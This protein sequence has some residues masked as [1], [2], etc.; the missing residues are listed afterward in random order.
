MAW[1][2]NPESCIA[3]I[4]LPVLEIVLGIDNVIFI[5][6]LAGK[7]P[8]GR[9]GK[10]RRL[11]LFLAMFIRIGLLASLAWIVSLTK[12]LFAVFAHDVSGRDVLLL[13][14]VMFLL[15]KATHEIH[16]R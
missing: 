13:G 4:P 2:T 8:A 7:L 9:Q 11:G 16:E 1:L 5:S 3:L 10:A 14:G 6:I 15:A 12:P